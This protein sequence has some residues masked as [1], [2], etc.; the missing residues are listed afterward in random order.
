VFVRGTVPTVTDD[1]RAIRAAKNED[2]YREVNE[3]IEEISEGH[4]VLEVLCE[5]ADA[6]CRDGLVVRRGEYEAVRAEGARFVVVPGHHD[7]Q[8]ERVIEQ[9]E[10]YWIVEKV[11]EAADEAERLDPRSI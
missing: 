5:C 9:T 11:G 8:V 3:R 10:R 1:A 4:E 2:L 6:A 7:Q